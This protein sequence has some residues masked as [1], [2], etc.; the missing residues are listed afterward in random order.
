MKNILSRWEGV[1]T[2]HHPLVAGG[3][4]LGN[5]ATEQLLTYRW[6]LA[7]PPASVSTWQA[8]SEG[9]MRNGFKFPSAGAGA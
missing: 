9:K 2:P 7:E 1:M 3:G 8:C 5:I 6:A 4:D